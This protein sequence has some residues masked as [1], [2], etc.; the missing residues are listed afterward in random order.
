MTVASFIEFCSLHNMKQPPDKIVKNLCTFLCQDT[1][2]TPTFALNRKQLDGILSYRGFKVTE[3]FAVKSNDSEKS[4]ENQ[5]SRLSRRGAGFAFNQLSSRFG[6]R[7]LNVVPNM[8][9]SMTGGL[10]SAFQNGVLYFL[11]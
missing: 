1:E 5:T 11:G 3:K 10:L 2:N 9:P 6:H 8:W 4:E 7:L